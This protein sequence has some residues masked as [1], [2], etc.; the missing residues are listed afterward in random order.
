MPHAVDFRLDD[1]EAATE[2]V[3]EAFWQHIEIHE[4]DFTGLAEHHTPDGQHSYYVLHDGSA[5]WGIPGEPQIVALHIQRD[6]S[7]RVFRFQHAILPLPG[8][9]QSWLIARGCSKEGTRLLPDA[10]TASA[11]DTTRALE[12]RLMGDG[13]GDHFAL[14][15]SYTDDTSDTP[16]ITVLLH[17][18]NEQE[19]L[20]F[21]V[22]LER[23]DTTSR[24]HTLR[25]GAF[26]TYAEATIWWEAHWSGEAPELPA[27]PA[28][29]PI[30]ALPAVAVP[31]S[32]PPGRTR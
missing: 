6:T 2:Q 14:L 20:P 28:G 23:I 17:A 22:L 16:E 30:A 8:M 7:T 21:R 9:A 12:E 4:T 25:E 29:T 24:T 19:P 11:D 5:T 15:T 31:A 13:G 26:R 18:V 10:R 32:P 3:G 1:F 27:L